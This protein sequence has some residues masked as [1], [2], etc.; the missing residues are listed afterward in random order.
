[1]KIRHIKKTKQEPTAQRIRKILMRLT[2][3]ERKPHRFMERAITM[4]A[5]M[6]MEATMEEVTPYEPKAVR[7][8]IR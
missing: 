2:R 8:I 1:M 5:A 4:E 3:E 7:R 6:L